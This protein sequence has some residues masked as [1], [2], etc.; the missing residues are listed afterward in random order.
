ME[1][2][3]L[4]PLRRLRRVTGGPPCGAAPHVLC[5]LS[6]SGALTVVETAS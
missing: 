1:L 2:L 4:V 6:V 3:G 5:F